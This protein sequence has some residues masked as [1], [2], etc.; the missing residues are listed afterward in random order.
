[1]VMELMRAELSV[2]EM[3]GKYSIAKALEKIF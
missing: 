1:M 2:A 3:C